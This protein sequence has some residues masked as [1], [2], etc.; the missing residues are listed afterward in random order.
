MTHGI[1]TRYL[2]FAIGF[3]MLVGACTGQ[4]GGGP[5]GG[6][7][8]PDPNGELI[9][10]TGSEPN[11][12]DPQLAS[13]SNEIEQ[14]MS[15]YEGLMTLDPKTLKPV[16]G[17][18]AKEPEISSDGLTWKVTLRDG[19]KYSDGS[20]LTAKNY[21]YGFKRACDIDIDYAFVLFI[22]QGCE[23]LNSMDHKK[24]SASEL[25]AA[26][27]KV[28]VKA[29]SDKEIEFKLTEPASY[30]MSI[31]YMWVGMPVRQQDV[32]KG[33]ER[34]T[35][36]A[37][38]IGNGPF[39]LK[40]WKH[41]DRFV[42]EPNPNFRMGKPKLA[43]WTRV[44][45]ADGSVAFAA[46]RNNELDEHG[47][48]AEDLRAIE[49]DPELKKQVVDRVS[50]ITYYYGFN[51]TRPPFN[52]ANVRLAFAKSFDR[53]A[54]VRDVL[55]GIG[56]PANNGFIPPG[57]PGYDESDTI[58]KYD[59]A[60]AKQL[61]D[62]ASPDAKAALSSIK[63]TYSSTPREKTRTEWVQQQWEKNL[64]GV[65]IALDP[66]DP[67]AFSGLFKGGASGNSPQL[68]R[69][70]WIAD[71]PDAQN[72][73]TT[74]WISK[75]GVSSRRTGF[76]NSKFDE[77]V[78]SAD[79][80]RDSKKRDQMYLEAGKILSQE[81]PAGWLYYAASKFLRKPWIKGVTDSSI[82]STMG[83]FR[84]WEIYVTKKTT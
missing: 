28:A 12:I 15:V 3:V 18:A 52:D 33:G 57:I 83:Q 6:A 66:V 58:Q 7:D 46:Y 2:A 30:F 1:I 22:V 19:L 35:E 5:A 25:Q 27:D 50:A 29:T 34:W 16:P 84:Q 54:F 37:T 74:V 24:A 36:P 63:F 4:P 9:T 8:Q 10:N 45:I 55:G 26:R 21:E 69:L 61:L 76:N 40:E 71:F 53:E 82:D 42:Y 72:W 59:V 39:I 41:N 11:T 60:A 49:A 68:F 31:L 48:A 70:G 77:L 75:S 43:K 14:I 32:E 79:K 51:V 67:S 47:V 62:K 64:P 38:Y 56:K 65:K 17:T 13:F 73:H 80:E 81:A 44:M 23:D 20:A 78:R